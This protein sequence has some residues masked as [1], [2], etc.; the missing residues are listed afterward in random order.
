MGVF[1]LVQCI[2]YMYVYICIHVYV[3]MCM[4]IYIYI[5]INVY[6]QLTSISCASPLSR[7]LTWVLRLWQAAGR[8]G[9]GYVLV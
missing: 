7:R 2:M 3:Y 5:H 1:V 9:S 6:E 4:N 8:S